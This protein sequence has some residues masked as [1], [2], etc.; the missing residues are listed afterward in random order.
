[1]KFFKFVLFGKRVAQISRR[2]EWPTADVAVADDRRLVKRA[3]IGN[4]EKPP[5]EP[6]D[7]VYNLISSL[8]DL[9]TALDRFYHLLPE[10]MKK[11]VG[12]IISTG[13]HYLEDAEAAI[14]IGTYKTYKHKADYQYRRPLTP[15]EAMKLAHKAVTDVEVILAKISKDKDLW[16][17]LKSKVG[18]KEVA[19][20]YR[21]A[22]NSDDYVSRLME[23]LNKRSEIYN[24][25]EKN[26]ES[27][28][29]RHMRW[30][31]EILTYQR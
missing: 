15:S 30:L 22:I 12:G 16:E 28:H 1:M 18:D 8:E 4:P 29:I 2:E 31:E 19:R 17:E 27:R 7:P 6:P 26:L 13:K 5:P 23:D 14:R 25:M 9:E 10:S 24:L 3:F 20:L 21:A 11:G